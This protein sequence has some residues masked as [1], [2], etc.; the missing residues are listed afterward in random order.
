[1]A[2]SL[3]FSFVI[4]AGTV[5]ASSGII[6]SYR[7]FFFTLA[8]VSIGLDSN[9]GDMARLVKGGSPVKLYL[10]GQTFNVVLTL[11]A[12]YVFFGGRFFPLPF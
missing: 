8:F 9:F 6:N 10:V 4:P 5:S 11:L 2:A 7:D 1:I 12:A 3:I